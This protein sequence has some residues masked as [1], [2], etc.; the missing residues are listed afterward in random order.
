MNQSL[1]FHLEYSLSLYFNFNKP[2]GQGHLL[3]P[4]CCRLQASRYAVEFYDI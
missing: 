3:H 2:L 4:S 1:S